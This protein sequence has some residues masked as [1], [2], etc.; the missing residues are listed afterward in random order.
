MVTFVLV[1]RGSW[2]RLGVSLYY[3]QVVIQ[4]QGQSWLCVHAQQRVR[5][6]VGVLC[7]SGS[8]YPS[9]PKR[10]WESQ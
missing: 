4:T 8:G 10:R 6:R 2:F 5:V 9:G 3:L 7:V 1:L